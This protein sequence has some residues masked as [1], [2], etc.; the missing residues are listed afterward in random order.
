MFEMQSLFIKWKV[1]R[2]FE[3]IFLGSGVNYASYYAGLKKA[4]V[5]QK[6][7]SNFREMKAKFRNS[8]FLSK[9]STLT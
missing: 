7:C 6:N 5:L 1:I 3:F 4:S 8:N 9:M 2:M